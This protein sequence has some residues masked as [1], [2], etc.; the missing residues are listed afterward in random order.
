MEKG[1]PPIAVGLENFLKMRREIR[2]QRVKVSIS[3]GS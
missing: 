3:W 2:E 1:T